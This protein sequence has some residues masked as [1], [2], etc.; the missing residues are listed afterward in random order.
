MTMDATIELM[1]SSPPTSRDALASAELRNLVERVVRKRVPEPE[2]DDL[3]QTVLC[4]AVASRSLPDE[5][6]QLRRWLVG[7]ARHKVADFHR[8]RSRGQHVALPEQ[9]EGKPVPH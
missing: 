4:D 6:E 1:A 7:I 2:V 9:I 5:P 8:K 3:V